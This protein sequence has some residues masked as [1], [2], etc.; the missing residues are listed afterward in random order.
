MLQV[1]G[2]RWAPTEEFFAKIRS[3][4]FDMYEK[5]RSSYNKSTRNSFYLEKN[6]TFLISES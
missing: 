6:Y 4:L 3:N 5:C 2:L 1:A